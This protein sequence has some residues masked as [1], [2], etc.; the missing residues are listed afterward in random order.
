[1]EWTKSSTLKLI[2]LYEQRDFLWKPQVTSVTSKYDREG[3]L[4]EIAEIL[5]TTKYDI[6]KKWHTLKGQYKREMDK[7]KK[8]MAGAAEDEVYVSSWY[9]F[10][11]LDFLKDV[12][13]PDDSIDSFNTASVSQFHL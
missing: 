6:R 13:K 12:H 4:S 8:F 7:V 9:A 1:M 2:E 11:Y 5:G 10:K 3:S